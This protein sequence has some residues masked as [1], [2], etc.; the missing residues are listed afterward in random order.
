M[1]GSQYDILFE[2]LKIGPVTAPNRLVMM[3]YA[4]GH[5]YLMPNGAI[6]IRETRAEGG[7]GIIGMQLSEIDPTSDLS[8]LPYER[9]WDDGD[10]AVHAR[11]VERIHANGALASIELAHTGI[12]SAR[13]RERLSGS[14]PLV[15]ANPEAGNAL[16]RAS[17]GSF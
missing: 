12:R 16:F 9:L 10:V 15:P 7:W 2:P 3:P 14:W 8:G 13:Y 1:Q 5:S 11:S 17:D 6:G 4:N